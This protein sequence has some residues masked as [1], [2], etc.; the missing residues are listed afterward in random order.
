MVTI[1]RVALAARYIRTVLRVNLQVPPDVSQ[2]FVALESIFSFVTTP[3]RNV[4]ES[5]VFKNEHT[6]SPIVL[7]V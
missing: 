3:M 1:Q 6:A 5:G 2:A 4:V 7:K